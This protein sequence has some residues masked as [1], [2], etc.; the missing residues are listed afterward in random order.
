[1]L[2]QN[3]ISQVGDTGAVEGGVR[4]DGVRGDGV[5]D[6]LKL[7]LQFHAFELV[8]LVG[9]DDDVFV[10]LLKHVE[11]VKIIVGRADLSVDDEH[12]QL[13]H[14]RRIEKIPVDE[15]L[16]TIAAFVRGASEAVAR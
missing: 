9:D 2:L 4:D 8:D 1:M 16:E 11:H 6:T 15:L 13:L 14:I 12:D 5:A 3:C 10:A 7:G